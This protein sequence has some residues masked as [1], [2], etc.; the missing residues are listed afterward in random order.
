M[1][2]SGDCTAAVDVYSF[3]LIAGEVFVG[4]PAFPVTATLPVL[5]RRVSQ[6]D[7]PQLPESVEAILQQIIGQGWLVDPATRGLFKD[8]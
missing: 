1:Y 5:F 6:G 2:N 3:S 8:I 4:K 7:R